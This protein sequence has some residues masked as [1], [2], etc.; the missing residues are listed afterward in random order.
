M[1]IIN[2][3]ISLLITYFI[4]QVNDLRYEPETKVIIGEIIVYLLYVCWSANAVYIFIAAGGE[5]YK[6]V[7]SCYVRFLRPRFAC[8]RPKKKEKSREPKL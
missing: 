4:A 1:N 7:K 2:E 3:V 5:I 6:S 8:L